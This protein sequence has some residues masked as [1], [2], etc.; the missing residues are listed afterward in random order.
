MEARFKRDFAKP[1]PIMQKKEANVSKATAPFAA[2]SNLTN[3]GA[4]N[5]AAPVEKLFPSNEF[6]DSETTT[7]FD[8]KTGTYLVEKCVNGN[9]Q[10]FTQYKNGTIIAQANQTSSAQV[11]ANRT[12]NATAN[13]TSFVQI[14]H[15]TTVNATANMT[16]N[17]TANQTAGFN[18]TLN[19]T[20]AA[21][22]TA[23]SSTPA[24]AAN[25]NDNKAHAQGDAPDEKKDGDKKDDKKKEDEEKEKKETEEKL[26]ELK[27]YKDAE[28]AAKQAEE[29]KLKLK[30]K[31]EAIKKSSE[32]AVHDERVK[33]A[34]EKKAF[35]KEKAASIKNAT[36]MEKLEKE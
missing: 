30:G 3:I 36:E 13:A 31:Q 19:L 33:T 17:M 7:E 27:K 24:P 11:T 26:K 2:K 6:S 35:W 21:N 9:C 1:T 28:E 20:K 14:Q 18:K 5:T 23:V 29:K 15:N 32:D 16:A 34:N 10:K 12:A 22:I 4:N 8:A 25:A